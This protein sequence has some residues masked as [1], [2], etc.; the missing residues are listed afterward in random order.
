MRTEWEIERDKQGLPTRL[1]W[2]GARPHAPSWRQRAEVVIRQVIAD[3]PDAQG[4]ELK[5]LISAAY[6]FGPRANHP[7]TVWCQTVARHLGT[8]PPRQ[9][10][11]GP[12]SVPPG[13]GRLF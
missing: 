2:V 6:P 9:K 10:S 1:W 3:H 12:D 13:Q 8:R 4:V 7:Y 11:T 5:R